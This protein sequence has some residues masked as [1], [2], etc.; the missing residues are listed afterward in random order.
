MARI[1][2]IEKPGWLMRFVNLAMRRRMGR[3]PKQLGILGHNPKILAAFVSYG[4]FFE[5][6]KLLSAKL[7]RLAH[8]RVALRVGCPS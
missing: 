5:S 1:E 2:P 8:L 7:K 6:S 3:A 4:A